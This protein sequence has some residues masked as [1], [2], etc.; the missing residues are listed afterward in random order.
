M[1]I[2]R[3]TADKYQ[4]LFNYLND[5]YGI[6]PTIEGM[7]DLIAEVDKTKQL[8]IPRVVS[9][10]K[11]LFKKGDKVVVCNT[12]KAE[13]LEVITPRLLKIQYEENKEVCN[14]FTQFIE[15]QKDL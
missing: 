1:N 2:D 6:N 15:H 14:E 12:L 10:S 5:Q 8:L 9:S 4:G 3:E 11:S 13:V 7:N